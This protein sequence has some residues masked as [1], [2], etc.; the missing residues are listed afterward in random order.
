MADQDAVFWKTIE[1]MS[2]PPTMT[3]CC[4]WFCAGTTQARSHK[5]VSIQ[6]CN[7]SVRLKQ[8]LVN[9]CTPSKGWPRQRSVP[10][11][12]PVCL[13]LRSRSMKTLIGCR[14]QVILNSTN[15]PAQLTYCVA[16]SCDKVGRLLM[17]ML[18]LLLLFVDLLVCCCCCLL[19][20]LVCSVRM[21]IDVIWRSRS[22]LPWLSDGQSNILAA[23]QWPLGSE[24]G[25]WQH[26]RVLQ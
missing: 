18:L 2:D 3:L 5:H 1:S 22:S 17:L 7:W 8:I 15:M 13:L 12:F 25:C 23:Q 6:T 4:K 11:F 9:K 10:S 24:R 21:T 20:L 19:F 16:C 14:W 26:C